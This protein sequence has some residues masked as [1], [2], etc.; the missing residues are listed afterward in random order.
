M[1]HSAASPDNPGSY[2]NAQIC[3]FPRLLRDLGRRKP[4]NHRLVALEKE[5]ETVSICKKGKRTVEQAAREHAEDFQEGRRFRAGVEGSI[6]VLKR[7]FKLNRSIPKK[8]LACA[9]KSGYSKY[10]T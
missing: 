2:K 5:I 3:A 6:S 8:P 1:Q 9:W 7:A 4:Q 10:K